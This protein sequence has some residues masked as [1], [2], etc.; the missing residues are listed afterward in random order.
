MARIRSVDFLPEIF[1]TPVNKQF[2]AATLDQL[3]Q[4]P[5]FQKTQGFV[6]RR[7]GPGVNAD[8]RY[9]IEPTKSRNDYQLEP[10]VI[11]I[12]PETSRIQDA[13]TY[14]GIG[15]ALQ[16]QGA[17]VNN[18]D[19]LYTSEYYTW[20]PFV[21]FD[22]LVNYQQYYWLPSGPPEVEVSSANTPLIEDF[23]VT[24]AD[25]VYTFSGQSGSNPPLTLVRGGNYS[26]EIA[27]NDKADIN[28]RVTNTGISAYVIDSQNNPTLTLVRGNTYTFTLIL[29]GVFPFFIK[30]QASLGNVNTY[31]S[32]VTNNGAV[33][34]TVTFV[35][36]QDAPD[37][38]YYSSSTQFNMRGTLNVV[39]G[40]AGTGP[41]FWIQT[42]PGVN[43]KIAS[44][45]NISSRTVL[46]VIN[47]GTDL[48]TVQF[49]VPPIT[50]QNF[51]YNL[52][53]I[54]AVS[55]ITDLQFDQID[56]QPVDAFITAR[57]GIDGI[58]DL[59]GRTLVF[60]T[61]SSG[62]G[63]VPAD[64]RYNVWQIN[65]V[66]ILG[67]TYFQLV[68]SIII[69]DLEKFKIQ[70]GNTWASTGWYKTAEGAIAQIPLL[71]A[72]QETLYYQDG[73]DPD[74]FG[75]IRLTS[76]LNI[77][78]ILGKKT[79]VSPNGVSFTNGLKIVFRG[80]VQPASYQNKSYYVEGVGTAIELLPVTDFITPEI[81]VQEEFNTLNL[82]DSSLTSPPRPD[83][84]TINRASP[85]LN[86]WT[87]SN[88]WFHIDAI[89]YSY[90]QNNQV[91]V[92]DNLAR[93]RRPILEF[94]AGTRLFNFGTQGKQPINV[95]DFAITDA[96]STINGSLG[97]GVDGYTFVEGSRVIFAA[98][99]NPNVR[100][101]IYV[102]QYIIPDT[103]PPLI[104]QPIINLVPAADADV[105]IDQTTVCL[106]GN[107][108][109]GL[110]FWFDGVTW[111]QAQEKT[112]VNQA[113]LF[114]VYDA[115][116][117]SFGD[118]AKYPSS[119]FLGSK[120]LSYATGS[121]VIDPVLG[122]VIKYLN[123]SNIG[124]I[125]FDNNLY[126]DTFVYVRD[127]ESTVQEVSDGYVR[128]YLDRVIFDREIGWQTAVTTSL[129]RQ[130]FQFSYD[131][132]P[133]K[134]DIAVATNNVVP[135]V[136]LFVGGEFLSPDKYTVQT[137]TSTTT[138]VLLEPQIPGSVIEI[139][140][141]SDQISQQAFYQVP[142]NL[143]N[144]PLNSN[145]STFT[146]GT[147]RSH[148]GT[149]GQ[150]LLPLQGPINGANN[151]RDLGNIIPYGLQILQQ[152]SPLTLAGYF[153]RNLEYDIFSAIEYNSREYIKYKNLLLETV[154]QN[155]YTNLS[156][157][158]ILDSAVAYITQGRTDIN[159]FYWSDMLPIAPIYT[160]TQ[161]TITPITVNVF[162]TIQTYNFT[163]A[164][165]QGLLVYLTRG[166][167][168]VLLVRGQDY[169]VSVDGPT[170]T[171]IIPLQVNDI[172]SIREY[173]TTVGNFCPNTP[174]KMGL[175]PKYQPRVFVDTSYQSP[176][177]VIQGHDGSITI[178][179]GDIRD[180]ILLEFEK[181]IYNNLKTDDNPVPLIAEDVIPGQF[182]TTDYTQ[183]EVTSI[184]GESFLSWVGWNKLDYKTQNYISNNPFTWNYSASGSKIKNGEVSNISEGLLLG[185]WHGIYRYFYD[186]SSPNTTPWEMLGLTEKPTW[187]ENKYGPAPYTRD[188][189]VLWDDLELGLIA[190]PVAP[191]VDLRYVRPGLTQVIP[192]GTEGQLLPP[193][194]SVM[195]LTDPSSYRKSWVVGDVGP[196]EYSWSISS[197]YPFAIM[198]LLA[199]T[200][201][202]EFFSLFADRDLYKFNT[203]FD[204]YL[205][206]NRYRL[207]ANGVEVY[208]SLNISAGNNDTIT[209]ISKASYI[210]WIVDYN[211]QLGRNS[212]ATLTAA[213][214]NIDVRLCY[215]MASFTDKQYLKIF[216]E[217]SSPN[218]QN[219]SLL[220]PD[221]SYN[222]L[223]YKNQP[224][225]DITYSSV[226]VERVATG[227]A[228]YGYSN[229]QPYFEI[230]A[231]S[232]NGLLQTV[233]SGG[234]SVRVPVQYTTNVVQVPYG[235]VFT[236]TSGVVDFILSYGAYLTAQ[237][238][239]FN[240]RFNGYELNWNQMAQEFLY[241]SQ[242]GWA[243]GTLINLNPSATKITAFREGAVV[244]TIES[245][246]PENMLLDQNRANLPTRDLIIERDGNTFSAVSTTNQSISYLKLRFV[247]YEH[248]VV[249]DNVSIFADLIYDPI[250]A[251]RQSRVRI[252]AATTTEWNGVLDAQGFI[253]NEDNV[254]EW[255]P[256][257]KY[258]KGE[259]VL[260]KNIYWSA[261]TIVQPKIL[262]DYNDWVKADYTLI[263]EGLLP[264]I[265]N[266]A[267]QLAN[268]YNTYRANLERDNDLLS[269]GLIG[270]RPREY[271]TALNLDDVS[272]VNIY[273][274]FLGNKGTSRAA[275]L[276]T[277][278][279]LGKETGE[280][281]IYENWAVLAGT[282][283]ANANRSFFELR[284]NEALLQSNPSTVQVILPQ[285]S[286]EANQTFLLD[287]IWRESF[288]LTSPDILPTMYG[289]TSNTALPSAGYVNVDDVD[290]TVFS[291]DDPTAIAQDLD[292]IGKGTVIWVAKV[293]S[294]DWNIYRCERVPGVITQLTDN[295][296]ETSVAL[297]SADHG[298][299]V[300]DLIVIRYFNRA[301][302]GVYRVLSIPGIQQIVIAFNFVN[303]NQTTITGTGLS[304]YLQTARVAQASDLVNLPYS[305]DL[306]A[307][308]KVWI[309]NN[310]QGH[311]TVLEKQN[312]FTSFDRLI[313]DPLSSDS[314]FGFSIAQS[315][316]NFSA[317]VGAPGTNNQVGT[318]VTYRRN[319][320]NNYEFNIEL[321]LNATDTVGFGN[322]V[323]FGNLTWAAAAASASRN[324]TGYVSMLYL[325]PGS[326]DFLFSQM[327]L[328]PDLEFGPYRFGSALAMSADEN[329][330]YVSAPGVNRVHAY[331][332]VDVEQQNAV[333]VTDGVTDSYNYSDRI[334]IDTAQPKQLIVLL[335][336]LI[337]GINVDLVYAID[338]II[339]A[340]DVVL[341]A[342]PVAGLRLT[343]SRREAAQ[344]DSTT[345]YGVLQNSTSGIG[346]GA[347]FTIN[348]TRGLYFVT[349][350]SGGDDYAPGNTLTI[351]GTVLGGSAPANNLTITVTT[352]DGTGSILTFSQAGNGNQTES[353]FDLNEFFYTATNIEAFSVTV[354]G[355]I[356]RPELD[357]DFN[358]DSSLLSGILQFVTL[359][360]PGAVIAVRASDY[361]QYVDTL[362][363][364]GL[365][366][367]AEFGISVTT[368]T[369][370]RQV[371]I[372]APRSSAG[373]T[374][375]IGAVYA[376][377]RT[378]IRYLITDVDQTT[379]AMTGGFVD[380]VF[381]TL[382]G[383]FLTN[384]DQYINGQFSVVGSDIELS[385]ELLLTVGD[386]LEIET[387]IFKL[388]Q[389]ITAD[390][391]VDEARFG[392]AVEICS[393]NCSLYA[394]S[395][396]ASIDYPQE[397]QAQRNV[398]QSRVY[399][400][401]TSQI[402]NPAL[403]AG[404]TLR[405]NNTLVTVPNLPNNNIAGLI[406][407]INT[408][409][410][411]NVLASS[412][413]D[414]V[415]LGDGFTKT[416]AVGSIYSA[417]ESY[418]TR[419]LVDNVVKTAG[420]DYTYNNSTQQLQFVMA[421]GFGQTIT[422]VSGRIT[423]NII[424]Q[425]AAEPGNRL[426]VFPGVN[427]TAFTDIGFETY[428][429]TQTIRSPNPSDYAYFGSTISIDSTAVNLVVGAPNG[430]IYRPVIFDGGETYFDDR[431]TTFFSPVV[432]SGVAYTFD[433]L[434]S[435]NGS[436]TNPAKLVFGQQI[437]DDQ[438]QTNDQFSTGLNYR[439]GRLLVGA[440]GNDLG[441]STL[442]Y[443]LVSVFTNPNNTPSWGVIHLEQPVV[444]IDQLNS[445][446]MYDRLTSQAQTYFDYI[447]PL[448]GKILG[449]ARRN[450]DYIGAVDPAEYNQGP[451]HN[452]GNSWAQEH[453]G[454]IWWDTDTVRFIDP[455]Q[456]NIDYASKKWGQTFPGSRVDIYQWISSVVP[457]VSYTGPG[458]PLSQLS[459][460]IA[461]A[462][463]QYNIFETSY[464]FWVR[465][466]TTINTPAGKTL[467]PTGIAS[468]I[469]N[470]RGSGIPYIAPLSASTVA[471]YNAIGIVSAADTILH[472]EYDR[473]LTSANVHQEY[474]LI[475]DGQANSFLN[476][477][478]YL[479]LLDSFSGSNLAGADVPDPLLSPPERYGVQ[480]RP[481][482]SMFVDR[483]AA[484]ENYLER[485]NSIFR[486][487][488]ITESR[489]LSLLNSSEPEPAAGSGAWN[490][491]V[492]NLEELSFQNLY[493]VPLGY[494]YLVVSDSGQGGLWTIYQLEAGALPGERVL[495]LI[496]VQNYDTRR[497]WY[498]IDWYDP[499]YNSTITPVAE[500]PNYS[501]L[502]T[503]TLAQVPVGSS[504][505]VSANAQGKFEIYL[506]TDL[507]WNRVGLESGTIQISEVIWNYQAGNFGFDV[508]VFDAQYFDQAPNIETR[509]II[510]AINEQLFVEDLA[511]Q[512]N[513]SLILMFNFVYSEF[514]A[515]EWLIK[516]SLIDVA[517]RIRGLLPFQ[518]YLQDNQEFVLDYIQEVKPYH[519]QIR[520]FNLTYY[521]DDLYP[522]MI[523]DYDVPAYYNR[524]LPNPQFVSPILTP[525]TASGSTIESN[526]SNAAPNAEIWTLSPWD[527][528]FNNYLLSLES[529]VVT[530]PGV[531]Y[532]EPPQV[533]IQ[534][535][536][537]QEPVLQA[538]INTT[539]QVVSIDI[540]DYGQGFSS[541]CV[542]ILN[543]GNGTGARARAILG[544]GLVRSI[545]TRIK[546]DRYEY[547]STIQSWQPSV[548]YDTGDL[549]RYENEV[550][551]ADQQVTGLQFDFEQWTRVPASTL[552]GINRT[553][554]YYVPT[555]NQ[556][557]LSLPLL[558][559]GLDYPGV[560]VTGVAFDQNTG[561]DVGNF[562]IN[563][564]D[565]ISYAPDG[566]PTY[567]LG[568]L[569]TM[570]G[571]S[572]L[573]I[574]LGTRPTDV[575][576]DGGAYIDT[577]SSHAPEEL[578]PGSEFDTLDLRVYSRSG[579]DWLVNG[580]GW[581][582][583]SVRYQYTSSVA[584][585]SWARLVPNPYA[586][587]VSNVTDNLV[588]D[589]DV[590]YTV[591]WVNQTITIINGVLSGSTLDIG[592]YGLGGGNQLYENTYNGAE[593]INNQLIIPVLF[594]EIQSIIGFVNG[595]QDTNGSYA[596]TWADTGTVT[597]YNPNGSSGT[598]LVVGDTIGIQVGSLIVGTG[599]S[600]GQTVVSKVNA[601]TLT[602]SAAPNTT[603]DGLLTFL[604]NTGQTTITFNN[605]YTSS[606]ELTITILGPTTIDNITVNYNFS[607]PVIEYFV[608]DGSSLSFELD[609]SLESTNPVNLIVM[610][611]GVRARTAASIAHNGD[612]ITTE[613]PVAGRLGFVQ[614]QIQDTDVIVYVDQQLKTLGVDYTVLAYDPLNPY[615][616]RRVVQ[617][618][619]A[620]SAAAKIILAVT[621]NCQAIVIGNDVVFQLGQGL[622][623]IL[624]DIITV[625][626]WNDTRQ[627]DLLTLVYVGPVN[628]GIAT[629]ENY[630]MLDF[631]IGLITNDPGS[632][633]Y[634]SPATV[635][636]QVNNL[637]IGR[638]IVNPSRLWVTLNGR[639]LFYGIDFTILGQEL[640]LSQGVIQATDV[641]IITMCTDSTVPE[642]M[643]F[644]IFQDMRGVQATYRITSS[645]TT[646]LAQPLSAN[647]D[648]IYVT[649]ASTLADP[650]VE[651][652]IW[653]II[654]IDGERIMYRQR[655]IVNNTI[656]SLLR[657]TG[658]TAADSH[659][660]GA[661]VYDMG[662][663]S[664]SVVDNQLVTVY[665]NL[666][667]SEFQNY[668]VSDSVIADGSTT[669]FAAP[670][671]T[672]S[673]PDAIEVFVGGTR[674][675]TGYSVVATAPVNVLIDQAPPA[676]VE[677]T[678]LIRRGVTWYAP[679]PGTPSN[680]VALQDTNTEAAR[681]LRGVN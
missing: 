569:D 264:N 671:I 292:N 375:E 361:W 655:N 300:G 583:E 543:G 477:T 439:G 83:Y 479:K 141:L 127:N 337:S 415:L 530:N 647:A 314:R 554:G 462:L 256:K 576:V 503:L 409:A 430:N 537:I 625:I 185:N 148:Y 11:G 301:V 257:R 111:A 109:E 437:Y 124:D 404:N 317:L 557:G 362:T 61:Q 536:Y 246:S 562:D 92:L 567:D 644:R 606:Q 356:Q 631:D 221:E 353:Q 118:R 660:T 556:P 626:T 77:D 169:I 234:T 592:V 485:A 222:L 99:T 473:Q 348:D 115:Q 51:F 173:P 70:F 163:S 276:F 290:I 271:M 282:Y 589:L 150:N 406:S 457:P 241:F 101:K 420:V 143:E 121:G 635:I 14:P 86:P 559:D 476:D 564:F 482:Q 499:S 193:S 372:G 428:V 81:Y 249:L 546:Y 140:V 303:T 422:V 550:Y 220:L 260:Y 288:K 174:T 2:L 104:T 659:A 197:S 297:F 68:N 240:D 206:N 43:G 27:Q 199:L 539:G 107:T 645:T 62:W 363:I 183:A 678:I 296:N 312:P 323:A 669:L 429:Y 535:I 213:L 677:V 545:C 154:I 614:D 223:L 138:I 283:G 657:G 65:Y 468:Y 540:L 453:V 639:R 351:L 259:I 571:S 451:I 408:A 421:P 82:E 320:N 90:Q 100:N 367:D 159:P 410:I 418:T 376:F 636:I 232:S 423:V 20:D 461:S 666:M 650:N 97:Y 306:V 95:I 119:T 411:P 237:G 108:L 243:T 216:T 553:Q 373:Q 350:L 7:V 602:I 209:G 520:E 523:N 72:V 495:D 329:W 245:L 506:R 134:L 336:N 3:V 413:P 153:A 24:R 664:V 456:D 229:T 608:A 341:T 176:T 346:T 459:Y 403:T 558:I 668:V 269:Y 214:Q 646:T 272:Q 160:E 648:I 359:P 574:Y 445:V 470:P 560:Q 58:T 319:F 633:D 147:I 33:A 262:F 10:G 615:D 474:Q 205:Y 12:E 455:N 179:F 29:N 335:E 597:V 489:N 613:F 128:E 332:K 69:D 551:S 342:T 251:S 371:L 345:Y 541:N 343:I 662:R 98:D 658:G 184:L 573:D 145:S 152:S 310:G 498:T 481:R 120:L 621:T 313:A 15:D 516:T 493:V 586:V 467:S 436:I 56:G 129:V 637:Q 334:Q 338:Y 379:Y 374:E 488:P 74:I 398:N 326:N 57:G 242:Q 215:R 382:N 548:T 370:G 212:T 106:S 94:R 110:S 188:N 368:T 6:G 347:A 144:N 670:S 53:D 46:G 394:G 391:A 286:S 13:I 71:S 527:Q 305:N 22:K 629:T 661:L 549:V 432:N 48:G 518:N 483:F 529:V 542:L 116:G 642:P 227:Y 402:A 622:V 73:T 654:T 618:T 181:R 454:E 449:V 274:Q 623:P 538:V 304:F 328:P 617:F 298:L 49:N 186:T 146:L 218:S 416:F 593:I 28:Y 610:V 522:G 463:N 45:P 446:F 515:P 598:T 381:V 582:L 80:S 588:L 390:N 354:N 340:T 680:G 278:A 26:F 383:V 96:L 563:P 424:N 299:A 239:I 407:A 38:L 25:G 501:E 344:I 204:Q 267:D 284:L 400:V 250:T 484:L 663:G 679:G 279:D 170:L 4:E 307:G 333:Y 302:D 231:S 384:S 151:S 412:T 580:H 399:G 149:I 330:L 509:Q 438:I 60:Q 443:G 102:V 233:S 599:F 105:L 103:E 478:L 55:L 32:G 123:L 76:I 331:A 84:L 309:D 469:E 78:N 452:N 393:S 200:R 378:V 502:D 85:D 611:N 198:R 265:A 93:G 34:G 156:V 37:I 651:I 180:Q 526:L 594:S 360:P 230:F 325:V 572:Y 75:E 584:T 667:P 31:D 168:T 508:E 135:A 268:S 624:G 137:T 190:D 35:V 130:Q 590:D 357:Y 510:R 417:A 201:P 252:T 52:T 275:E 139:A 607:T 466:I 175:Y 157:D 653:G 377:D 203:E 465:G 195:G 316:N 224:F 561:F 396:L 595:V 460:T 511:I 480:F 291:L 425:A 444:T 254:R 585:Y 504:V 427:G 674:L 349:L 89:N 207:D 568:I 448:Q 142:V 21:D 16:L 525:Y 475:A 497:Y 167:D 627:Q 327:L 235:Y 380:P 36:P 23:V 165:F 601:T 67:I 587:I 324:N 281:S 339:T 44:T 5:K 387:N 228:I 450:I 616:G 289:V 18:A 113:P 225:A 620:P 166:E 47:N 505:K 555:V 41:G 219:S 210:N 247:N 619:T 458:I 208:G 131:V 321:T 612:G 656:S 600:S 490:K 386:V 521:G 513:R 248:M 19:R 236:N 54:G 164:N 40:T 528:W 66:T 365:N 641:V 579:S 126:T 162:D 355:Q 270:F 182:R 533:L 640:I 388:I 189:L 414:L 401:I 628:I 196:V 59:N 673:E 9:V 79:Y 605:T 603:P 486:T 464:Y 112:A 364:P 389:T 517:H 315:N 322:A 211:Q 172:V 434:P 171:V 277:R 519:V 217:K 552:S 366:N 440:P 133:I 352:V 632:F 293:N 534:G 433:L 681:F 596:V 575:N 238:L 161:T 177:T 308:A 472:I 507:G 64:Q 63:T 547:T 258:T 244:D 431:S 202:A 491:R 358:S 187:W 114:N 253:L 426:T 524:L 50:A 261:Q 591:D 88:R 226:I 435:A 634:S 191:Y 42:E 122:L 311:W 280:Y 544:N 471:I 132:A 487:Y 178:T 652:N 565:N 643:A 255:R 287:Q 531:G 604:D 17:F 392:S 136:Q 385:T 676:G 266:K 192:V 441:D 87:R 294:Y 8:D 194:A 395:P 665:A 158:Q 570:Y 91:P 39:D 155:E 442:N 675:L 295:L 318:V 30:T 369:D 117:I 609:A 273:Q 1:Q 638:V 512:R 492:A 500:V 566:R 285:Q 672:T 496:R 397:G 263:Q 581:P 577:Y 125:V 649:D 578:V 494:K 532:T 419:V 514:A 405:I 447:N 630:D